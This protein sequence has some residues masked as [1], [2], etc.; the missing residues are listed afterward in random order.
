MPTHPVSG[1]LPTFQKDSG[2]LVGI[3]HR[4][5]LRARRLGYQETM[6]WNCH[7]ASHTTILGRS[8]NAVVSNL[9][10]CAQHL[11]SVGD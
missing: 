6:V 9:P 7:S 3:K 11:A 1:T 10:L 5:G 4:V 2:G 8:S